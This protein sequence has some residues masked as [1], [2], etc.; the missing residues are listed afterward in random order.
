MKKIITLLAILFTLTTNAQSRK[1]MS[2]EKAGT[3][4]LAL[5]FGGLG[6]SAAGFLTPPI[7]T[8]QYVSN[9]NGATGSTHNTNAPFYQQGPR[10]GAIVGGVTITLTGLITLIAR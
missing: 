3:T 1:P 5:T 9:G 8:G 4:G 6:F 10:F 2:N 7:T